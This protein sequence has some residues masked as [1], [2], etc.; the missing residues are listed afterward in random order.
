MIQHHPSE[1]TLT[2]YAA[3]CLPEG[4]A[5][6]VATHL[7]VCPSCRRES[8]FAEAIGGAVLDALPPTG[9]AEDALAL[10][11]ARTERP[12][13]PQ[14]TIA[15]TAGLPP[16]LDAC[17]F[18]PWHRIGFGLRWRPLAVGGRALVG[19]LEGAPGKTLP[20]HR[21]TGMELTCVISGSFV[22][23]DARFTAGDLAEA[24]ADLVHRPV[25]DGVVPCLSII[26]TEGV[27]LR[28]VLGLAQRL[29]AE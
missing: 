9:M 12:V 13:A 16:P 8:T 7:H 27:R 28:G 22:D 11:L 21:H 5:L 2:A 20:D 17:S 10:V 24:D 23:G 6:V 26:A 29:L 19:L 14:P 25:I 15:R 18:G 3:G 1:T 4:L